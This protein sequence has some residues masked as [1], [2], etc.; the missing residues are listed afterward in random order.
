[1]MID[2]PTLALWIPGTLAML[3]AIVAIVNART[4]IVN[5]RAAARSTNSAAKKTDVETQQHLIDN[6]RL[7]YDRMREENLALRAVVATL[8]G[9]HE[10]L[11]GRYETQR[12]EYADLRGWAELRGWPGG[13]QQ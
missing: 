8:R 9:D 6:L 4:A 13:V 1:M 12:D 3:G 7:G 2:W 11:L 10:E 5:A